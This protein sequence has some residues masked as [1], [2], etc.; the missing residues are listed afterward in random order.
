MEPPPPTPSPSLSLSPFTLPLARRPRFP[1]V[2]IASPVGLAFPR[3]TLLPPSLSLSPPAHSSRRSRLHPSPTP[4]P[5]ALAFPR[6]LWLSP[7]VLASP[8]ALAFPRRHCFPPLL[9]LSPA[10]HS[11]P[12]LSRFPLPPTP[13]VV[14][15]CPRRPFSTPSP[16]LVTVPHAFP[17]RTRVPWRPHLSL[18]PVALAFLCHSPSLSSV[19]ITSPIALVFPRRP[20]LLPSLSLSPAAIPSP[21]ALSCLQ[22]PLLPPSPSLSPVS[23]PFPRHP[24]PPHR[25][26]TLLV[27]LA[28]P[29]RLCYTPS[30]LLSPVA[31]SFPTRLP[32]RPRLFLTPAFGSLV[33]FGTPVSF[34]TPPAIAPPPSSPTPAPSP[35]FLPVT[36]PFPLCPRFHPSPTLFPVI[37]SYTRRPRFPPSPTLPPSP[38]L[39]PAALV[40]LCRPLP[41]IPEPETH[42]EERAEGDGVGDGG[43]ASRDL[44]ILVHI[45]DFFRTQLTIAKKKEADERIAYL[46]EHNRNP[47]MRLPGGEYFSSGASYQAYEHRGVMQ[48]L[49]FL[50]HGFESTVPQ[51]HM[52]AIATYIDWYTYCAR[53][54]EHTT[55]TLRDLKHKAERLIFTLKS[56]FPLQ[57]SKW[58]FIKMHL[59]SHYID[60]IRRAGLPEHYSTQMFE[61]LHIEYIKNP[62]RAS[63]RRTATAQIMNSEVMRLRLD[64]IA[65]VLGKRKAYDT[66]MVE[67]QRTGE[68]V[69]TRESWRLLV[70]ANRL[71]APF[72]VPLTPDA[73]RDSKFLTALSADLPFLR[74]ALNEAPA[75]SGSSIDTIH[76]R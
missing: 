56:A 67:A 8:I 63:N 37:L 54:S 12:H 24:Y 55:E 69:M 35:S 38:S 64:S 41:T 5:V 50:V 70:P 58:R 11:F 6:R 75:C 17:S 20:L 2:V 22:H 48:V 31:S 32:F 4:S 68:R 3:R 29:R 76:V 14:L 43:A 47:F 7:V 18:S 19:I 53:A 49:P 61:H 36:Q 25:S 27:A 74:G 65:P 42:T 26:R 10:A 9:S 16:T 72:V 60:S 28:F 45:I 62:Y 66:C 1:L 57:A 71:V 40:S 52:D 13:P 44:G 33:A 51:A 34:G 23:L 21:V 59:I 46:R 73:D 15:V 39:T 30:S